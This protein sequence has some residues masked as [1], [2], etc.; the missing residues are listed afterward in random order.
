M[1][2]S[3]VQSSAT[4]HVTK[5][6]KERKSG[7]EHSATRHKA[8]DSSILIVIIYVTSSKGFHTYFSKAKDSDQAT[9]AISSRSCKD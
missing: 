2:G 7:A 5:R 3:L 4:A 6:E 1:V 8:D 9:P